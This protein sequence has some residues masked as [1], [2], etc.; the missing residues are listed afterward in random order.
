[1]SPNS[2]T[3]NP[4]VRVITPPCRVDY[5]GGISRVVELADGGGRVETWHPIQKR[6]SRRQHPKER[7]DGHTVP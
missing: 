4:V 1:M 6:W 5:G 2:K 3:E 7:S